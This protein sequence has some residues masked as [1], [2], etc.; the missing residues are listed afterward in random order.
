M[1]RTDAAGCCQQD[2]VGGCGAADFASGGHFRAV[3]IDYDGTLTT[4]ARPHET[5][6]ER[7]REA[8]AAGL[9]A[10]LV[11]G[12]ILGELREDFPDVERHFDLVVAENGAVMSRAGDVRDLVAPVDSRL[13]LAL[14]R[15][16][17]PVRQG[18][19][20]L[21]CDAD[22]DAT[23]LEEIASLGL[24]LQIIRNRG[25][26]M[27]LPA[28]VTKGSG[29]RQ[30]LVELG[31]SCHSTIAIGDAEN[32][33]SLLEACEVGA[34]VANAVAS[35]R[36]AADVVLD[37]P[38]GRGVCE[39]LDGGL[40]AGRQRLHPRR[41]QLELGEDDAGD[42]VR[43]PAS[44]LNVL[45]TGAS[46]AG[47]SFA[48]GLLAEQ[49]I[50]LG[51]TVL[52]FDP[53][54]E[55][56]GLAEVPG[57]LAYGGRGAPLPTPERLPTLLSHR[58]GSVIL[59][60]TMLPGRARREY[61]ADASRVVAEHRARTG[62]PH[63]IVIDEAHQLA[64]PSGPARVLL[65][66]GDTGHCLVTFHP[67]DVCAHAASFIDVL[68]V[69]TGG[70]RD[71]RREVSAHLTAFTGGTKTEAEAALNDGTRG[72]AVIVSRGGTSRSF[73]L[74][75]R[76]TSHVRHH[77]KYADSELPTHLRFYFGSDNGVP[78]AVVAN[79][80]QFVT[81]VL[82]VPESVLQAHARSH[83]LSRWIRDVLSDRSLAGEVERIETASSG[84]A[85]LSGA[86][87]RLVEVVQSRYS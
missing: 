23:V 74:T 65:E 9:V 4:A 73:Q 51:Y 63:W 70:G 37:E 10:V 87:R 15:R 86:R 24:E 80:T 57:A 39:L 60:L 12:R 34:A 14:A 35:L 54:G 64:G 42:R 3:A 62:L 8:R 19:V 79:L 18:R 59:D 84:A 85:G 44:Q 17:V 69:A 46:G 5:V 29:V 83:D 72:K 25:A 78:G 76:R 81:A 77:R 50:T 75:E 22:H 13:G 1:S 7:L 49:L 40:V 41:W 68:I 48:A 55:H 43:L 20:L 30:G 2:D 66:R 36:E 21:A 33:H 31:I 52:V 45:V 38:D 26:L 27:V 47:K 58:F 82:T 11:T 16:D 71:G 32:D 6:L 67:L 53:T 28:G 56:A 61:V